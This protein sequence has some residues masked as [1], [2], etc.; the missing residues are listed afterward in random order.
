MLW[1]YENES[2]LDATFLA[3]TKTTDRFN[4]NKRDHVTLERL[5][6]VCTKKE[7]AGSKTNKILEIN[8]LQK[9]T[10]HSLSEIL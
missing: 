3:F 1:F 2:V 8:V 10:S 9:F 5:S 6:S 7:P 4:K